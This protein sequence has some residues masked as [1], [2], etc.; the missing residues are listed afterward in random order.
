MRSASNIGE[1][2]EAAHADQGLDRDRDDNLRF[3]L[4]SA[5]FRR[6]IFLRF[7][8]RRLKLLLTSSSAPRP[9]AAASA[10][11][12]H[13][14]KVSRMK[15]ITGM[16]PMVAGNSMERKTRILVRG[17]AVVVDKNTHLPRLGERS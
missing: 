9:N 1:A 3:P 13:A 4:N 5:P 6:C 2:T 11:R 8:L 14:I 7:R 12:V 10:S 16:A 15:S 17:E